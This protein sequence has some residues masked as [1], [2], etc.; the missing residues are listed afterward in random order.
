MVFRKRFATYLLAHLFLAWALMTFS[1][2]VLAQGTPKTI[3]YLESSNY[4]E[5]TSLY[6]KTLYELE[7][8]GIRDQLS[9]PD[10]LHI[11][12]HKGVSEAELRKAAAQ[13]MANPK[14]ELVL[15]MGTA[16]TK[17]M[18]KEN[19]DR[20]PIVAIGV[21]DPVGMKFIDP[22]TGP[23][24]PN[25]IIHFI[26]DQWEIRFRTM[27]TA[28]HVHR[29]G[30]MYTN[31]LEGRT[32]SNV[33]A[34]REVGREQGFTLIEYPYIHEE[35]SEKDCAEGIDALLDAGIDAFY[36]PALN[37][38]DWHYANPGPIIEKLH[39]RGVKTFAQEGKIQV[40]NGVL[41]GLTLTNNGSLGRFYAQKIGEQLQLLS[42]RDYEEDTV[43]NPIFTINLTT[44]KMLHLDFPFKLLVATDVIYDDSLPDVKDFDLDD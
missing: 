28:L 34:A 39:K 21:S 24:A 30:L 42:V 31:T 25:L 14:V 11:S 15:S 18:L 20:V 32:F 5:Y 37:C 16:A 17:A 12:L 29:L 27:S 9:F 8:L 43:K 38:F 6:N 35:E 7:E 36:V 10:E 41:M 4:W 19:N 26:R 23:A 33:T 44:A 40:K 1:G 2:P 3:A 13:L 22:Y